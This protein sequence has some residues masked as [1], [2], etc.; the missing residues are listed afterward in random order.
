MHVAGS[1]NNSLPV[2]AYPNCRAVLGYASPSWYVEPQ[3][4]N[5]VNTGVKFDDVSFDVCNHKL[6]S[7]EILLVSWYAIS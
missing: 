1:V 7:V 5:E 6:H 4:I 2:P 3:P